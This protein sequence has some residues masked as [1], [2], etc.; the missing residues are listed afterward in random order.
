MIK[1]CYLKYAELVTLDSEETSNAVSEWARDPDG[2]LSQ[3][4]TQMAKTLM[5][6]APHPVSSGKCK[7]RHEIPRHT[8]EQSQTPEAPGAGADQGRRA[9]AA[10]P[11][12]TVGRFLAELNVL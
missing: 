1:D 9:E 7:R 5:N 2:R 6:D 8:C 12:G 4:D 3:D 10:A 11:R